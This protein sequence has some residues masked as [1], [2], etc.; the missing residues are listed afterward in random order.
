MTLSTLG[1][2]SSRHRLHVK[3]IQ[4]LDAQEDALKPVT[5]RV[6]LH[7]PNASM[8]LSRITARRASSPIIMTPP[9]AFREYTVA[10]HDQNNTNADIQDESPKPLR[11]EVTDE[12]IAKTDPIWQHYVEVAGT[13]RRLFIK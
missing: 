5:K 13:Y 9:P 11:F 7:S 6:L 10:G 8:P 12:R 2:S 1:D 4:S 3:F